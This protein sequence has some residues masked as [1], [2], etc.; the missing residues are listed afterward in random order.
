MNAAIAFASGSEEAFNFSASR[1]RWLRR[2][3]AIAV[4]IT[5]HKWSVKELLWFRVP[6]PPQLPKGRGRPSK[7][8]LALKAQWCS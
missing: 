2:T 6:K 1:R 8:F 5:D 4:D 7:A 3:P